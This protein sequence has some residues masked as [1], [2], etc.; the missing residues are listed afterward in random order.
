MNTEIKIYADYDNHNS[1]ISIRSSIF[2]D[3]TDGWTEIDEWSQGQDRYLYAH[4]DN[5]EYVQEKH[6]KPLY[7]DMGRP[8]F[9]GDFEEWTDEE[10]KELY[11]V[12]EAMKKAEQEATLQSMIA[13]S[14]KVAFMADMP[15]E[16]AVEIPLCFEKWESYIGKAMKQGTRFEYGGELWKAIQNVPTVLENQPPSI[17]TASLYNRIDESHAGTIEDPIPYDQ[18]MTVHNGKYYLEDGI[19]YKC[20]RDSGQPLYATC[21]SLVG[22]Y[23]EVAE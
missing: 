15:D 8:N 2:L 14:A 18:T 19:T 17:H 4:A 6:G 12:E 3:S 5:G 1:I 23:F 10:K 22:N 13:E 16:K 20:I 9:H 7:D 21:A 11:P